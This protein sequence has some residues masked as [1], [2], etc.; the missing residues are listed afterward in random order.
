MA[1]E[2][3]AEPLSIV[4]T[5]IQASRPHLHMRICLWA[6]VVSLH[7]SPSPLLP[8]G[9]LPQSHALAVCAATS[10]SV[11]EAGLV[12]TIRLLCWQPM[13]RMWQCG[14]ETLCIF[15]AP[16]LGAPPGGWWPLA[17]PPPPPP[18][19]NPTSPV[20]PCQHGPPPDPDLAPNTFD[21]RPPP[22]SANDPQ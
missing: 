16:L 18:Y 21:T 12:L 20:L 6:P 14:S 2:V 15:G 17:P 13:A 8:G 7:A 3:A 9:A 22:L 19:R 10:P 4:H 5:I 1:A 11:T